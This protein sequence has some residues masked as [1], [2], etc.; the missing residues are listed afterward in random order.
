MKFCIGLPTPIIALGMFSNV[1]ASEPM[2]INL[3]TGG[4][5]GPYHISGQMIQDMASGSEKIQVN[6]EFDTGG[7]WANIKRTV[8]TPPDDPNFC[9]V[10]IGQPDGKAV[11]TRKDPAAARSLRRVQQLHREYLHTICSQESDVDALDDLEDLGSE[12]SLILGDVGSGAWLVWSNIVFYDEDYAEVAVRND[13]GTLALSTVASNDATCMLI[14]AAL[15]NATVRKA[16]VN[17]GDSLVLVEAQDKDFNDAEDGDGEALYTWAVIPSRTYG[18]H[19]QSGIFS[20]V[21]TISWDAAVYIN[22]QAFDGRDKELD[23]FLDAVNKARP[24]ILAEFN[25]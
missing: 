13:T 10:M 1:A 16:D 12:S 11:L 20:G 3:C 8:Q 19:L 22:I 9:H 23:E 14:P 21:D 2:T 25:K 18:Q 15:G 7:T 5:D 24:A 17:Y 6:V 4:E